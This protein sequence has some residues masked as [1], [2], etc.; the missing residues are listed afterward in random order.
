MNELINYGGVCKTA[1]ATP[2]LLT[3]SALY[4]VLFL[5]N[6]DKPPEMTFLVFFLFK[7]KKKIQ[8]FLD[9]FSGLGY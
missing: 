9:F 5:K 4:K 6:K 8:I 3:T 7:M 1:P 2:G